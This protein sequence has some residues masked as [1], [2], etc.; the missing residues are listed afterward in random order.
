MFIT[1]KNVKPEKA[2][3]RKQISGWKL[4]LFTICPQKCTF[5]KLKIFQLLKMF[6]KISLQKMEIVFC[7]VTER[8]KCNTIKFTGQFFS[9]FSIPLIRLFD[10]RFASPFSQAGKLTL[11]HLCQ[12][13]NGSIFKSFISIQLES[14]ILGDR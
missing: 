9:R 12:Y 4:S 1:L 7:S 5:N 13:T 8:A 14:V 10:F 3:K 11:F 2:F 6:P